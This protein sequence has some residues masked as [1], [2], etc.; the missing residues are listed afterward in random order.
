MEENRTR[1]ERESRAGGLKGILEWEEIF[2]KELEK[3]ISKE[4]KEGGDKEGEEI[5][6]VEW[7][8]KEE[9]GVTSRKD[10]IGVQKGG[11]GGEGGNVCL[12]VQ[13]EEKEDDEKYLGEGERRELELK[14]K[15]GGE[16]FDAES[17]K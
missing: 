14:V 17:P 4:D 10:L 12:G 3:E 9:G 8:G 6:E 13:K 2:F 5:K 1:R 11:V 15:L 16:S 7:E